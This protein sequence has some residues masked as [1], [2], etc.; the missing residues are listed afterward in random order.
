[1]R[2]QAK[3]ARIWLFS[4]IADFLENLMRDFK[5]IRAL[6]NYL[7]LALFTWVCV[8]C[9]LYHAETC[10][11]TVIVTVGGV[12]VSI[13]TNYVWSSHMDKR[14]TNTVPGLGTIAPSAKTPDAPGDDGNG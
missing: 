2:E 12:V 10:G 7:F 8:W 14:L 11:N 4:Q 3:Q 13:F 5:S 1:M 9:V 6:W